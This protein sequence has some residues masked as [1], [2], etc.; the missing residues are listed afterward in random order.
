VAQIREEYPVIEEIAPED[1]WEAEG[2]VPMRYGLEDLL[3]EPL[4]E[5]HHPFLMAGG[6][7][8]ATLTREGKK[9]FMAAALALHTG[10]AVME[11]AAIQ[12]GI[13]NLP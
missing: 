4:A 5:L 11:D 3:T 12:V 13:D 6:A 10:E 8:V 1:L 2:E 7:E 9:V